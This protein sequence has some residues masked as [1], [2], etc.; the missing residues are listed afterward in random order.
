[1]SCRFC[2][3]RGYTLEPSYGVDCGGPHMEIIKEPCPHCKLFPE[4][5]NPKKVVRF[6]GNVLRNSKLHADIN[7]TLAEQREEIESLKAQVKRLSEDLSLFVGLVID[8]REKA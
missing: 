7:R 1:M 8:L 3:D 2:N 6:S 5:E 4:K